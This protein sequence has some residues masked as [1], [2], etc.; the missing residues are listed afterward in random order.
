MANNRNL[1]VNLEVTAEIKKAK[2]EINQLQEVLG[3]IKTDYPITIKSDALK[4]VGREA[5][6]V[7]LALEK[8]FNV[9]TG[10]LDLS[11]FSQSLKDSK[12][13]LTDLYNDFQRVGKDGTLAIQQLSRQIALAETPVLTLNTKMK[14][15]LGTIANTARWQLSSSFLHGA[16]GSI[17]SAINYAKEL[18]DSLT[19]IQIVTQKSDE[20]MAKFAESANRA[21]KELSTTTNRY[22]QASL[23]YF[24]QGLDAEEVEKRAAITVKMAN[25]T[26]DTA[27]T[28]SQQ[29]TSVW[30]NFY[31]GSK[32]LE[33]YADGMTALGAAT[34]TSSAE[35]AQ[36]LQKFSSIGQTVG[37]SYEYAASALATITATTRQ[38]ADSVGTGLRTLFARLDSLKL[39]ETLE[40]GVDLTK[41]TKP[42]SILIGLKLWLK[43]YSSVS[44]E[45][46]HDPT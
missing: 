35:I 43:R 24:Q 1:K 38:S 42:S 5:E 45:N 22:A 17:Q 19:S 16:I 14:E 39:G 27:E 20:E 33:S 31:D 44:C 26:G 40:D 34:A 21:A 18:N 4:N 9:D 36:G 32:S 23:I 25:V 8:A 3:R 28:V 30:N 12:M 15:F 10:K 41:Y 2:Q 37:L 29:L 11:R 6:Q 46:E 13:S 7:Q